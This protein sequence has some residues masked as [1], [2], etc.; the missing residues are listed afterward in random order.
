MTIASEITRLQNDKAAICTA[1]ENKWVTV[2]AV[3]LDSYA[4]CIDAIEQWGSMKVEALIVAWWGSGANGGSLSTWWWGW[5]WWVIYSQSLAIDKT[6]TVVVWAW[7]VSGNGWDSCINNVVAYGWGRWWVGTW[8]P[9]WSWGWWG[10]DNSCYA[11]WYY[12]G[13]MQWHCGWGSACRGWWGW[14]WAW[15]NGAAWACRVWWGWWLWIIS[16]IEWANK[17]Y[18]GWWWG[19]GYCTIWAGCYWGGN[20][21]KSWNSKWCNAT[22]C[23]SWWWGSG[24][25]N[26]TG[27]NWGW[28]VVIIR[29]PTNWSYWITS[30]TGWNRCY[31]CNWYCIHCFS[32]NWTFTVN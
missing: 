29:Y 27:G 13:I 23:W 4:A 25:S 7:W 19:Y 3:T 2:W 22:T 26:C 31:V 17:C 20:W 10:F 32:S 18:A 15:W 8:C 11:W 9:W 6:N 1:I 24:M 5:A 30:S 16:C 21:W 14:G 12:L 28:W